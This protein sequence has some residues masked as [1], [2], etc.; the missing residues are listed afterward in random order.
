MK[1][2]EFLFFSY[3]IRKTADKILASYL[4]PYLSIF[5]NLFEIFLVTQSL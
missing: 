2:T 5:V 4:G 3:H 1:H